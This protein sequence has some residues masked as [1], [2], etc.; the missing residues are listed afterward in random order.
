MALAQT[1]QEAC[2]QDP[3][4]VCRQVFDWTGSEAWAEAA[5]RF[6]V[7]PLH[8]LLIVLVAYIAN[9]LVRRSIRRLTARIVDSG[10]NGTLG[11]LRNHTPGALLGTGSHS[12]RAAARAQ[13][14]GLVLRSIASTVIWTIAGIM[15]LGELGVALGPL[16]AG[17]GIAGVALGFG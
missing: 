10:A 11:T 12:M 3:S 1:V 8:I 2:G 6:V 16:I 4:L 17:A 13:T 7:P 14:L 5:D 15:I 9:R